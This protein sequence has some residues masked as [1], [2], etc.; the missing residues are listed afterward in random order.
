MTASIL[1]FKIYYLMKRTSYMIVVP[2]SSPQMTPNPQINRSELNVGA[3]LIFC[4]GVWWQRILNTL[5]IAIVFKIILKYFI[6]KEL[7]IKKN[8][9][10]QSKS[11]GNRIT[12]C[13]RR[14]DQF[15]ACLTL[16]YFPVH[17][18]NEQLDPT[19]VIFTPYNRP[20]TFFVNLLFAD[21][22]MFYG[23]EIITC[24]YC[25]KISSN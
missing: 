9:K 8:A 14:S 10:F 17:A 20:S 15:Q 22:K 21:H 13:L 23:K 24:I 19:L 16:P 1:S 6:I 18:E 3:T 25:E 5:Q 2:F 7:L 4:I 12:L 11:Q